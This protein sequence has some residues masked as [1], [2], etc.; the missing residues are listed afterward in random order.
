MI[1]E[2]CEQFGYSRKHAIKLLN[3]RSGWGGDP[4]MRKGRPA[5][6]DER[7]VE[8]LFRI[9]QAAEQPTG[10]RLVA[11]LPLWLPHYEREQGKLSKKT[12]KD[13]L[14]V[15]GS[16]AD[17]LLAPRKARLGHRGRSATNVNGWW[18]HTR[19]KRRRRR[20][21]RGYSR[22]RCALSR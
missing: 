1:D 17:R 3:A 10:V 21:S 16:H 18:C 5:R 22:E 13:V 2:L 7:V 20:V 15:S 8:V 12:R 19:E 9:W 14:A 6:Y 11:A 4:A